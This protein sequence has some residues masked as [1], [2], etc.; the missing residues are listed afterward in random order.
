MIDLDQSL[1]D[2]SRDFDAATKGRPWQ[3]VGVIQ[4]TMALQG[5]NGVIYRTPVDT[6]R[7]RGNWQTTV[8]EPASGSVDA[9]D[10]SGDATK[11]AGERV[12][13]G[14]PQF[15]VL[16]I[17]NNLDYIDVL[18]HGLFDPADPGPS[19]DDRPGR[20]GRVLVSG[21]YSVQAPHGMVGLTVE[22]IRTAFGD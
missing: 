19:K 14:V 18:E 15:D 22:E 5:L 6:G 9:L 7:A 4:R 17:S 3:E 13:E 1:R 10:A 16:W 20:L 8:G 11:Q 21:G 2:F 12:I